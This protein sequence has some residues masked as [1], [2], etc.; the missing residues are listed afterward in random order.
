MFILLFCFLT[1]GFNFW[2]FF[3]FL[4]IV[5][6]FLKPVQY[7]KYLDHSPQFHIT[8]FSP[9]FKI[10]TI[11]TYRHFHFW[12]VSFVIADVFFL[13]KI[14]YLDYFGRHNFLSLYSE[15]ALARYRLTNK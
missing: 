5:F 11:F 10:L 9:K 1:I 13:M 7:S 14:L 15:A 3:D 2:K 6:K 8:F 4:M 12:G